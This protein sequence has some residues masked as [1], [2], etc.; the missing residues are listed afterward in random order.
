MSD[1][2]LSWSDNLVFGVIEEFIPMGEPS[3]N[4][5]N[6]EQDWEHVSWE[7]H[8]FIDNATVEIDIRIKL[9]FNKI[10]IT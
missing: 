4:S 10:L 5:R 2:I 8:S 3:D 7:S 1:I 9:S 6:H